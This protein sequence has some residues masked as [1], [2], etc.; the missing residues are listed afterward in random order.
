ME[1]GLNVDLLPNATVEVVCS[2][3]TRSAEL[4][5]SDGRL[6]SCSEYPLVPGM[7]RHSLG[8]VSETEGNALRPLGQ[9]DG[10]HDDVKEGVVPCRTCVLLP[11]CGGA[12]PKA[13][14]EGNPPCPSLRLNVQ[15]RLVLAGAVNGLRLL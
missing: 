13:W 15:D 7:E 3:V 8:L 14:H 9:F 11:V 1:L 6:Y 5:S 10:W 2:A 4:I 12:C